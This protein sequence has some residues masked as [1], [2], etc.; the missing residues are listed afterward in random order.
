MLASLEQWETGLIS[1]QQM[2]D[3]WFLTIGFE[4]AC[5]RVL[6]LQ[7]VENSIELGDNSLPN[8]AMLKVGYSTSSLEHRN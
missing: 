5:A 3:Q 7:A 8:R 6:E 2:Y 1:K 4:K